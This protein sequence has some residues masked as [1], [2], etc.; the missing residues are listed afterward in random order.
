MSDLE[1]RSTSSTP[2]STPNRRG[3]G[4]RDGDH[5]FSGSHLHEVSA[6][7]R[8]DTAAEDLHEDEAPSRT[9]RPRP[10][11]PVRQLMNFLQRAVPAGV[12][13]VISTYRCGRYAA[14]RGNVIG[15]HLGDAKSRMMLRKL[16]HARRRARRSW[17][18]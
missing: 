3:V 13:E 4:Q 9:R 16:V 6:V 14:S 12:K 10:V 7:E 2:G 8:E 17:P 5:L 15:H 18:A 1:T 11:R